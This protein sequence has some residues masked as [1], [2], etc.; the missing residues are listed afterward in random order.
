MRPFKS[1]NEKLQ[2]IESLKRARTYKLEQA[3]DPESSQLKRQMKVKSAEALED[4]IKHLESTLGSTGNQTNE[5]LASMNNKLSN[6]EE[7]LQNTGNNTVVN[8]S[9]TNA[10]VPP[11]AK[12]LDIEQFRSQ[13]LT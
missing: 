13:A 11:R 3:A 4:Q 6:L 1:D 10:I 8:S 12:T 2:A 7:V 5:L 9:S